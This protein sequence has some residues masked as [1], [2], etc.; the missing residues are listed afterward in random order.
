MHSSYTCYHLV[1]RL[2]HTEKF[3]LARTTSCLHFS[4]FFAP[5]IPVLHSF[6]SLFAKNTLRASGTTFNRGPNCIAHK[7]APLRANRRSVVAKCGRV[8]SFCHGKIEEKTE[9]AVDSSDLWLLHGEWMHY[10]NAPLGRSQ[11]NI[12]WN[13]EFI[14]LYI[15]CTN[16]LIKYCFICRTVKY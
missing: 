7:S 9:R 11:G 16:F 1:S 13:V 12:L 5:H 2:A 14:S 15:Y 4:L 10:A 6:L 8:R 3:S